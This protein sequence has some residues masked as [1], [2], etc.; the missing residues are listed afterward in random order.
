M[1]SIFGRS[2]G[3]SND[4]CDGFSRR[5]FLTVGGM[6][7]GGLSLAQML[8]ADVQNRNG[9]NHRA[10]INVYMPGG[11]SHLDLWDLKPNAPKEIR[12]E[13]RPIATNVPG[14]E[15]CELFPRMAR[16]MDKFVPVRSISD[17]DGRHDA[18]Q[19]MT[20]WK[21]SDQMPRE[22]R[23]NFGAWVAHEQ[24]RV[25][26]SVPPNVSLCYPTGHR[27]WGETQFGGFLGAANAPFGLVEKDPNAKSSNMVLKG[28]TLDRL[29]NRELLR[30]AFDRFRRDADTK[31][32]VESM[33]V[34]HQQA[35]G[36]LTTTALSDALDVSQD[37]PAVL[38]R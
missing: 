12:G 7:C 30:S 14:I 8:E 24:G 1:F 34:Y 19:C 20:G 4:F 22:G 11:P 32:V 35:L 28:I 27:P 26:N 2:R 38:S 9:S 17:A 31:G 37:S 13:F 25:N 33:D 29:N 21:K 3:N 23:P 6:A 5:D 18:F 16:M 15:I 36:I 10:I